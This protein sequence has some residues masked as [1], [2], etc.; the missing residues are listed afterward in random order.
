MEKQ[1]KN[2]YL[3]TSYIIVVQF[4]VAIDNELQEFNDKEI[5]ELLA[6]TN[7]SP[8][9]DKNWLFV[10]GIENYQKSDK[11]SFSKRSAELFAR[12]A[13]KVF[14]VPSYN[15]Y[16]ITDDGKTD[17]DALRDRTYRA[18]AGSLRDQLRYLVRDIKEGDKIY[19]YYS[20]H[21]VPVVGDYNKPYIMARDMTPDFLAEEKFFKVDNIYRLLSS[22]KASR[23]IAF[24]DSCFTGGVDGRSIFKGKASAVLVPKKAEINREKISVITA[25][26]DRQFSNA[27]NKKGHRLFTYYLTKALLNNHHN[28]K[29]LFN[30]VHDNTA[31][32]SR[33]LG[34]N[35]IQTPVLLGNDDVEL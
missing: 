8:K 11:I 27:Y 19:F 26:S 12:T 5:R 3:Q 31:T 9:S 23:V 22:S 35:N 24:M 13:M 20:G 33:Q 2:L 25:G 1:E 32:T 6:K 14:G 17:I 34:G 18:T 28:I 30:E 15:T 29:G 21:G 7:P 16:F 10:V 4:E